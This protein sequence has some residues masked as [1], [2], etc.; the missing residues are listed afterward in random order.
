MLPG[1]P[2]VLI[3]VHI[4]DGVLAWPWL[5]A[6]WLGAALLVLLGARR[7]GEEEIPRIALLTAAFFVASSV[8]VPLGP[9]SAHLLLNGLLGVVLGRRAALAILVGLVMQAALLGHGGFSTIGINCCI[10]AVPALAAGPLFMTLQ[11][12]PAARR[13]GWHVAL[14]GLSGAVFCLALVFVS[15]TLYQKL[16]AGSSSADLGWPLLLTFHPGTL[17]AALVIGLGVALLEQQLDHGPEFYLGLLVGELSVLVTVLLHCAVLILGGER[18]WQV[19]A[20]VDVLIHLPIAVVEGIVVG[21]TVS[22]MAR[23]KPEMLRWYALAAEVESPPAL[24]AEAITAKDDRVRLPLL[25]LAGLL[26]FPALAHAHALEAAAVVRPGWQ[27]QVESWYETGDAP[28][29]ARVEVFGGNGRLISEGRLNARGIHVFTCLDPGPLRI[30]VN[31]G[32]GHR[33]EATV[34]AA[35]L[36]RSAVGTISACTPPTPAPFLAAALLTPMPAPTAPIVVEDIAPVVQRRTGPQ[37]KNLLL[38]V[39]ALAGIAALAVMWQRLRGL[40]RPTS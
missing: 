24:P 25:V 36:A 5:A 13:S 20:L 37:W 6:G 3:A 10:M 15:T 40:G 16:T 7:V 33:A 27:V 17:L 12:W 26:L 32:A 35:T 2:S 19:W 1:T 14:V 9:A 18:D 21:F 29:G 28:G 39:G 30:V 11:R 22:F 8:H 34:P 38:G 31:A 23:V 4:A